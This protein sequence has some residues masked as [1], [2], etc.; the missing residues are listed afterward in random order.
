VQDEL[1]ALQE[2]Q[3][4]D[5]DNLELRKRLATIPEELE[6]L[7]A[8]VSRVG[9]LLDR[10][11]QRLGEAEK[12][13]VDREREV[14]LKNELMMKSK[15]KLQGARNERESKAA[16]R[17]IDA[18]RKSIQEYEQEV[19]EVIEVIEQYGKSIS[20]HGAEFSE[21]EGHLAAR[22]QESLEEM[23]GIKERLKDW[24]SQRTELT[25]RVPPQTL[26]RYERIHS[27]LGL[28][29]AEVQNGFCKGCNMEM[30]PQAYIE[31][32]RGG[33]LVQ[34]ANCSRILFLREAPPS[35]E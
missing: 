1:V 11:R 33:K 24:E 12:M 26:R 28:A 30:L 7:R 8:D 16:Q 6:A 17:E 27:R 20:E 5:L 35:D 23:A 18:I 13:R 10:E 34:C 3:R 21:L 32:Q 2:L 22:E 29:V 15:A 19:L 4:L 31:L 14:L 25:S 9:E